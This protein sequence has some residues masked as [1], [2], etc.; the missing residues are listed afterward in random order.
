MQVR[1]GDAIMS[2]HLGMHRRPAAANVLVNVLVP[3][4]LVWGLTAAA[5]APAHAAPRSPVVP[6]AVTETFKVILPETSIAGPGF[7]GQAIAWTGTDAAHHV[8]LRVGTNGVNFPTKTILPETSPF[9]PSLAPSPGPN[10]NPPSNAVAWTGT[11]ANHSLNVQIIPGGTKLTLQESS[12]AAPALDFGVVGGAG[13]LLLA[14]TGT[15]ANHSLNTLL[16]TLAPDGKHLIPGAKTVLRLFSSDAGPSLLGNVF[17]HNDEFILGWSVHETQQLTFTTDF[18]TSAAGS[19]LPQTSA[20]APQFVVQ[21]TVGMC[22]SW[23]GTDA[24]N[25][26]NVQ[27]TTQFPQFPDPAQTKTVLSETA[28]G[29]PG[30][31]IGGSPSFGEIAW[32]GTDPAQH[33][34]VAG[35]QGP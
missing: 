13:A 11:D 1:K 24:A 5:P 16:L 32:T 3:V 26:L 6:A 7:D 21:G 10:T 31:S 12:I 9:G 20:T 4:F 35:L 17:T 22:M 30:M 19:G 34:N 2:M 28:L 8:N 23:T 25:H 27:C 14:W 33:L 15:D 29:A 18:S